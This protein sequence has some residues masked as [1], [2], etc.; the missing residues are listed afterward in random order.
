M[1]DRKIIDFHTHAFP[2]A[3]AARAIP[4]LEAAGNVKA[5]TD[6]TC[7]GL[8]ASM[9]RADIDT[10]V[11][12][13]IAT[14]VEQFHPILDW[15]KQQ[16]SRRIIPLPSV[17]PDD[18]QL[19]SHIAA[20]KKHGFTGIKLHPYYQD[21]FLAE[22]KMDPIY[23]AVCDNDLLL[24]SHTG[25]DIAY[26]RI[27]RADPEQIIHVKE[28]FPELKLITTHMGGW[29]D[30]EEVERLLIGKPVYLEI[31][32]TLDFLSPDHARRLI[33]G[34]PEEFILFGT[35]SPWKDQHQY[36]Q[37]L[38]KLSLTKE[39]YQ[40]IVWKNAGKLLKLHGGSLG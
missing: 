3:V 26:P 4:S 5:F 40:K 31:S 28:K 24:V 16:K 32:F 7:T 12:C 33:T 39:L 35:D 22:E 34:H 6:G 38:K 25:F 10:S 9:D 15:S 27:R 30:W 1:S 13:S 18:P 29:D 2:D 23:K 21:F 37:Q 14:R 8:L 11:I 20:I 36:L 17:H 19:V